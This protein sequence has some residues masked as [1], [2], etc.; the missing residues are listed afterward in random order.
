M[1][2]L[3]EEK[4]RGKQESFKSKILYKISYLISLVVYKT[5]DSARIELFNKITQL[6]HQG[7]AKNEM[8]YILF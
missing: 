1:E 6:F 3:F 5:H 2:T 7:N 4:K 8:I